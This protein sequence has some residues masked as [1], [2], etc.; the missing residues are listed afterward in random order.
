MKYILAIAGSDCSGGAGIQADIRT[1]TSLGAH[2]LTAITALTAQN[3]IGITGIHGIPAVF[4]ERQIES[5]LQ[6]VSPH[7]VKIGMLY[8]R[9]NI[10]KVAGLIKK[11]RLSNL[12]LDP[13]L[14][15]TTGR[16]LIESDAVSLLKKALVPLVTVVTPNLEEAAL[17]SGRRVEGVPEM[18]EAARLIHKMGTNVIVTGG[19]LR[20]ECVDVLFEGNEMV[21]FR[22]ERIEAEHIHGSGCVFSTALAAYLAITGD[23]RSA[24]GKAHEFAHVAIERG[25]PCGRGAGPVNP[26]FSVQPSHLPPR[27]RPV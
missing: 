16:S 19:H 1:I 8:S 12:V 14:R 5:I 13:V 2:A 25:Y 21:H 24:A 22:S 17:L 27:R 4:L 15:A 23:L 9:A 3:S 18:E 11:H 20:S 10:R 6:D 7:A 26:V